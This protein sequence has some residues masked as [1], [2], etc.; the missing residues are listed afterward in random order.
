MAL[1]PTNMT[2]KTNFAQTER[3]VGRL[4]TA[5]CYYRKALDI[6]A[7]SIDQES[8]ALRLPVLQAMARNNI[9]FVLGAYG[10]AIPSPRAE[11]HNNSVKL[12]R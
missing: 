10:D 3:L 11:V 7:K 9:N 5:L 12:L 2:P 8:G 1:D 4:E 6:L